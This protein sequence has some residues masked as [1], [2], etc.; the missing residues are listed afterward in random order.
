MSN[1]G[2]AL[3]SAFLA[4]FGWAGLGYLVNNIQPQ[5]I[6]TLA[7]FTL[8]F[9]TLTATFIPVV[10]YLNHRFANPKEPPDGWRSIRQSGWLALFIVLCAW[11]QSLRVL[12]WVVALLL[13]GVFSLIEIFIL[14]RE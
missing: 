2:L 9:A 14:T 6:A 5:P 4:V 10:C 12:N 1:R 11:L 13:L 7:F 8:L 3:S